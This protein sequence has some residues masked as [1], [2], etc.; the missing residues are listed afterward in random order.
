MRRRYIVTLT[1]DEVL[2][3]LRERP[4]LRRKKILTLEPA[5]RPGRWRIR[6]TRSR[7]PFELYEW[8][9][10]RLELRFGT[11]PRGHTQVDARVVS[12]P[13]PKGIGFFVLVEPLNFGGGIIGT[14]I[15]SRNIIKR[16]RDERAQL[17]ALVAAACLPHEVDPEDRS[18]FRRAPGE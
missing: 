15:D 7:P 4:E 5:K 8:M 9:P 13:S 12:R 18:A 1:P 17:L 6:F 2:S 3:T 14:V 10:Q 11:T 16:R